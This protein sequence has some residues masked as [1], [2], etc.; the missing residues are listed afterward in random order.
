MFF[1]YVLLK[2]E[3]FWSSRYVFGFLGDV[4]AVLDVLWGYGFKDFD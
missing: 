1:S 2:Q 3:E 4:I